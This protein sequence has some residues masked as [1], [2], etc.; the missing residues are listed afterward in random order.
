[1]KIEDSLRLLKKDYTII[2]VT[3][4]V[5]QAARVADRAAF[6]LGGELIE[7]GATDR[8]FTAPGDRR[9]DDYLRGRF[10]YSP[11]PSIEVRDL[12]LFYGSF[13]ALKGISLDIE[14]HRITALIGPSGC[15]KS[16]SCAASTA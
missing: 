1:M 2:L 9:T 16:T 12:S 10:G 8:I 6:F 14:K 5:K 4:N 7:I 11:W 15:G 13:Q 3:N